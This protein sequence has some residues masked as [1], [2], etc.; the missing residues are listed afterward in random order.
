[1]LV[2]AIITP[3]HNDLYS[4]LDAQ[5]WVLNNELCMPESDMAFVSF[6]CLDDAK[7]LLPASGQ[8]EEWT[9]SEWKHVVDAQFLPKTQN[10]SDRG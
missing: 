6:T 3:H 10:D 8:A 1:M 9:G 7:M 4:R 5:N 2:A